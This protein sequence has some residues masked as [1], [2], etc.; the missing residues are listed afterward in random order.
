MLDGD[1]FRGYF[2]SGELKKK[3]CLRDYHGRRNVYIEE[4]D[5]EIYYIKKYRPHKQ[6]KRGIAF[7]VTRD[8]AEHYK[9]ISEKL[10]KIGILHAQPLVVLVNRIS[11]FERESLYV[12]KDLGTPFNESQRTKKHL[13]IFFEY[14]LLLLE[15]E[16]YPTD[17]N[18]GGALI[19]KDNELY[20]IDF[21]AYRLKWIVT[22]KFKKYVL[23]KYKKN[24]YEDYEEE[25]SKK[26]LNDFRKYSDLIK[27]NIEKVKA[28]LKL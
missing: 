5:G 7:G 16:I 9:Y 26:I 11:F 18:L 15:N 6:R 8:R 20:L 1:Y 3:K 28:I 27:E 19:G 10:K 22:K 23:E 24:F 4:I 13:K 21:D 2:D 12:T 25:N 17:Y 14:F